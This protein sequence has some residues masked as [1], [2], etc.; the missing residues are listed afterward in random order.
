MVVQEDKVHIRVCI[1]L[2]LTM[3]TLI[4]YAYLQVDIQ[5][6]GQMDRHNHS[7]IKLCDIYFNS[8]YQTCTGTYV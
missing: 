6:D 8:V 3:Y 1:V 7:S 2:C 4:P 5:T